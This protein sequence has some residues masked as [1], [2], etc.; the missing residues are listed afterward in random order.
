MLEPFPFDRIYGAWWNRVVE[1]DGK[2]C[3]ERS[4]A[5]YLAAIAG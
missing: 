2:A 3:V 1:S 4:V 5:R